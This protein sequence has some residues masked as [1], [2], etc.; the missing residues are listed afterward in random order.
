MLSMSSKP[1]SKENIFYSDMIHVSNSVWW[2]WKQKLNMPTQ[3]KKRVKRLGK[4]LRKKTRTKQTPFIPLNVNLHTSMDE[5]GANEKK[6]GVRD[7]IINRTRVSKKHF[8]D[9]CLH[10]DI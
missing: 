10:D 9:V 8:A 5:G 3:C 6:I 4:P 7:S 2:W 1:I